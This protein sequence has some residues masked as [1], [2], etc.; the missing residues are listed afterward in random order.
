M[1]ISGSFSNHL[2][3][4][5]SSSSQSMQKSFDS[6]Y[7][8]RYD[9]SASTRL[10]RDSG[11]DLQKLRAASHRLHKLRDK[12]YRSRL[13]L[14]E[15]RN[16]LRD[17][18]GNVNDLEAKL[19]TTLRQMRHVGVSKISAFETSYQELEE[20]RDEFGSL[21]YDYD[22][23]EE[24]HEITEAQLEQQEDVMQRILS[25]ITAQVDDTTLEIPSISTSP[26]SPVFP[27]LEN[28]ENLSCGLEEERYQS[29]LGDARI[30]RE[31]L[32]EMSFEMENRTRRRAMVARVQTADLG[33]TESMREMKLAYM[34]T[35]A[36]LESIEKDLETLSKDKRSDDH[37][38]QCAGFPKASRVISPRHAKSD[39]ANAHD[40][41]HLSNIHS[42]INQ[43]R[44]HSRSIPSRHRNIAIT[45]SNQSLQDTSWAHFVLRKSDE[46]DITSYSDS[47]EAGGSLGLL[48]YMSVHP[49]LS[50]TALRAVHN[51]S[52]QFSTPDVPPKA[53]SE[54]S[55]SE[56]DRRTPDL[57]LEDDASSMLHVS[58]SL[59]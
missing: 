18:R 20:R 16:E 52:L 57:S 34:T 13:K 38:P 37:H 56:Y 27:N 23:A 15:L 51:F 10:R 21:Q 45:P 14:K 44:S 2:H 19:M 5:T 42:K 48:Q 39:I 30:V 8:S 25:K 33:D 50:S 11:T 29:R 1:R 7:I 28:V 49:S 53:Q 32:Q 9:Q 46:V 36:E 40:F 24:E 55:W 17:E 41:H 35:E 4:E 43:Q 54:M 31:R 59:N 6:S 47:G 12:L 22:Q 58:L 26:L 3:R